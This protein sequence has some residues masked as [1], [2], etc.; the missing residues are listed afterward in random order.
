MKD[1]IKCRFLRDGEPYGREYSY[2]TNQPV[3]VGDIVQV[4]TQRGEADVVVTA[5]N[6][7]EAEVESFKDKLKYIIGKKPAEKL[8]IAKHIHSGQYKRYGDTFRVWDIETNIDDQKEIVERC[9]NEL[10]NGNKLPEENEWKRNNGFGSG[11][12]DMAYYFR[13][14]YTLQKTQT[15]YTFTIC[16]PYTD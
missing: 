16:E 15:G 2:L 9:F 14:Y 6:V 7:P 4:E 13:G 1:I 3:A 10:Y 8:F 11:N 12:L 5:L